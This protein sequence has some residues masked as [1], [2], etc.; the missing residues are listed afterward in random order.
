MNKTKKM[1]LTALFTAA[2]AVG[3]FIKIPLPFVP[4]V[5]QGFF[6]L[7]AGICLG[8][9]YGAYSQILYLAIGLLGVPIFT[10]GGGIGYVLYP[11]FGYLI[12]YIFAA[13]IVGY[14]ME[15]AP[16]KDVKHLSIACAVGTLTVYI[17]G[18]PYLA[19]ILKFVL[20][21]ENIISYALW[22]GFIVSLP[23]DIIK[24]ILAIVVSKRLLTVIK[25]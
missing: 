19:I 6:V 10:N 9:R 7:L 14:I 15:H 2:T 20:H 5:L 21:K 25:N 3:A 16:K 17:F 24:A 18:V 22:S 8:S 12:G 13:F 4:I 11:T 23:A 1:M